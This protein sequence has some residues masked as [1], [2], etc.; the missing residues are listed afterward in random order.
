MKQF[1]KDDSCCHVKELGEGGQ[2]ARAGRIK[3]QKYQPEN[4]QGPGLE[5]SKWNEK[6]GVI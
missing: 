4:V 2:G 3:D 5:Q 1:F 6:K